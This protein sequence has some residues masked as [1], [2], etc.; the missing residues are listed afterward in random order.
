MLLGSN[1]D[2]G[3]TFIFAGI[4]DVSG[5]SFRNDG[6][7]ILKNGKNVTEFYS[8]TSQYWHDARDSLSYV[9][10]DWFG[11]GFE[12]CLGSIEGGIELICHRFD[13]VLSFPQLF[14]MFGL[15]WC[16][17][18]VHVMQV[19]SFVFGNFANFTVDQ[20]VN[21][22]VIRF[23]SYWGSFA[24]TGNVNTDDNVR[25]YWPLF[26]SSSR[27]NMRMGYLLVESTKTGQRPVLPH[28]AG[29]CEFLMRCG[30]QP[31]HT[32]SLI[33]RLVILYFCVFAPT[34]VFVRD[35]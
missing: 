9:L 6:C 35:L 33:V 21:V 10:T 22:D 4:N 32:L 29:V 25:P 18:I 15:P 23:L 34:C 8:E 3:A 11:R 24:R 30:L 27:L 7:D 12:N 26:N 1:Q 14:P 17:R 13:H 31:L 19:V 16:V 2:E 28:K 20:D 5:V